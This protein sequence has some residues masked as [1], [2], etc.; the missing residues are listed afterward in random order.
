LLRRRKGAAASV[1]LLTLVAAEASATP[2]DLEK[3][4]A[5]I[6]Q[7]RVQGDEAVVRLAD[8]TE[9]RVALESLVIHDGRRGAQRPRGPAARRLEPGQLAPGQAVE[10]RVRHGSDGAVKRVRIILRD[11]L[12]AA[13]AAVEAPP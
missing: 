1:L 13:Q 2:H 7:V 11:S 10:L 4:A 12:Q 8:G 5:T 6:A 3:K 9:V